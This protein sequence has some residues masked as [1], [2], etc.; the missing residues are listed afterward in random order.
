MARTTDESTVRAPRKRGVRQA[1]TA[2]TKVTYSLP[3]ALVG[4]LDRRAAKGRRAR[5][6]VV[7]EALAFYFAEDDKRALAAVYEQAA[8]DAMFRAD[9]RE[10][11]SDFSA[12]DADLEDRD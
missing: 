2:R 5:S 11:L 4:E 7:S 10:V 1:G 8:G 9:N 12:L 3:A 6:A